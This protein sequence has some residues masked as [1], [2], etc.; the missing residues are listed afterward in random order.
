VTTGKLADLVITTPKL[1]A[2]QVTSP[3]IEAQ[4][5]W[6]TMTMAT[7]GTAVWSTALQYFKS[8]IGLVYCKGICAFTGAP[9]SPQNIATFP[10]GYR[11]ISNQHFAV[12]RVDSPAA[13]CIVTMADVILYAASGVLQCP[14]SP[15]TWA[16]GTY[17]FSSIRFRAEQ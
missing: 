9:A 15:G 5:A 3:K 14:G 12:P 17:D 13:G 8:S 1:G 7:S 11:P 2:A 10:A 16:V 6:Q 4:Q